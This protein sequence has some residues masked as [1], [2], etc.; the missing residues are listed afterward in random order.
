MKIFYTLDRKKTLLSVWMLYLIPSLL[1]NPIYGQTTQPSSTDSILM[2]LNVQRILEQM[3]LVQASLTKGDNTRAFEHAYIS[4]SITLPSIKDKLKE[5]DQDSTARLE[6][7][8]IDLPILVKS[9][10]QSPEI[11]SKLTEITSILNKFNSQLLDPNNANY[12]SVVAST[13]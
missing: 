10:S 12:Y 8:L 13:I 4:H 3:N 7:L 1:L 2:A 9:S 6:S 11:E 5:I